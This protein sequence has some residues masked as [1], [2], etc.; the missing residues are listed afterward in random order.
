MYMDVM[1]V[2]CFLFLFCETQVV[3]SFKIHKECC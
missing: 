2:F 3:E 1:G